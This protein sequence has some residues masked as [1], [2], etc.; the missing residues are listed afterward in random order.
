VIEVVSASFRSVGIE[1]PKAPK[2]QKS[3]SSKIKKQKAKRS[4]SLHSAAIPLAVLLEGAF[5][6]DI[7]FR[8]RGARAAPEKAFGKASEKASPAVAAAAY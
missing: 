2:V 1:K 8:E 7:D 3:N 6:D 5:T 4:G